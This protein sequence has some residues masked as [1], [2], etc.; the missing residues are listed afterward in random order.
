MAWFTAQYPG[1]CDDCQEDI[2][3]GDRIGHTSS[4]G[5][6]HAGCADRPS[7]RVERPVEVCSKCFIGKPCA[8]EDGQ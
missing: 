6:I 8:C 5:Y 3:P 4:G 1:V 2:D 7:G